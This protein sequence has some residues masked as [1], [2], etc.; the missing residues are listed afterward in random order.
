M[1]EVG[2]SVKCMDCI[3]GGDEV[4]YNGETARNAYTR[5]GEHVAKARTNFMTAHAV[6]KHLGVLPRYQ[7]NVIGRFRKDAMIRQITDAVHISNT[8]PKNSLNSKTEWNY[9]RIPQIRVE[10][11][12]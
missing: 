12:D 5:G 7:M 3:E 1:M 6:E 10:F 11:V 4:V 9:V 2:Y 8:N